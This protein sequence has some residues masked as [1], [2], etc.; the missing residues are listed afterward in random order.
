MEFNM[1]FITII[2]GMICVT[3]KG[4]AESYF[5]NKYGKEKDKEE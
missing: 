5:E 4:I 1:F 3:I 2:V